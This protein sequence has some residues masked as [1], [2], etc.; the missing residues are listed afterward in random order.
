MMAHMATLRNDRLYIAYD[1]ASLGK[2][3]RVRLSHCSPDLIHCEIELDKDDVANMMKFINT[4]P[5]EPDHRLWRL[6][7]PKDKKAD[8][9][10]ISPEQ[11]LRCRTAIEWVLNDAGYKPPEELSDIAL[12]WLHRLRQALTP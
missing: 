8:I 10:L 6:V 5:L 9:V 2:V 1:G 7:E 3:A 4:T 11:G 12:R